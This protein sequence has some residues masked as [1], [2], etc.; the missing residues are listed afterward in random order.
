[1]PVTSLIAAQFLG[2]AG[3]AIFSNKNKR[4]R[5]LEDLAN[6]GSPKYSGGQ[7]ISKYY[8]E[9]LNRYNVNPY[10]SP[11]YAMQGQ[12]AQRGTTQALSALG[13][14]RA[15]IGSIG[16]LTGIQNDAMLK[17]GISAENEQSKRFG[18]LGQAANAQTQ[19]EK[20]TY[21]NNQLN[22]YLRRLQ[23]AQQ[24]AAGA[25]AVSS[26][27]IQNMFGAASSGV[28]AGMQSKLLGAK[29]P[30]STA[31]LGGDNPT[32]N[33]LGD[34]VG[35]AGGLAMGY[36]KKATTADPYADQEM[37]DTDPYAVNNNSSLNAFYRQLNSKLNGRTKFGMGGG[38]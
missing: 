17:A 1:M 5:E 6:N 15:G 32:T 12:N 31:S 37:I 13:D 33:A 29:T 7:S 38:N 16:K 9:A 36:A 27:G 20:Y 26:A 30:A 28:M 21:Q 8:N 18:V 11:L 4:Q 35:K 34:L 2:G 10:S 3:Q 22:P 24:K 23:I 14:R 25:A 19:N